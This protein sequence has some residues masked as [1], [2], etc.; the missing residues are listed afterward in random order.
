M[1]R[2][3]WAIAVLAV[4]AGGYAVGSAVV[5][6]PK[7][8][9]SEV[10]TALFDGEL[11]ERSAESAP[12]QQ[13]VNGWTTLDLMEIQTK[14][15]DELAKG[16]EETQRLLGVI[17]LLLGLVCVAIATVVDRDTRPTAYAA[18]SHEPG[19]PQ[20]VSTSTAANVSTSSGANSTE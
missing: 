18:A 12:Q 19:A 5:S 1:N 2:R 20:A 10:R 17:A 14:Q 11:N 13:V 9:E 6:S 3:V 8:F 4:V 7:S 15:L 16:T